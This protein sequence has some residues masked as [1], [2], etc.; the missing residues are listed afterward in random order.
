[1]Y[2]SNNVRSF[3]STYKEIKMT[4]CKLLQRL[5]LHRTHWKYLDKP[6]HRCSESK[7]NPNTTDCIANYIQRHI[8]CRAKTHG[9]RLYENR[10]ELAEC[11]SMEQFDKFVNISEA[12]EEADD[13][14][15]YEMTGCLSSCEKDKF[16]ITYGVESELRS[17]SFCRAL[18]SLQV[19]DKAFIEEE[20]YYIYDYDSF[21]ADVGGYM[22]LLLGT[23]VLSMYDVVGSWLNAA[24]LK[25]FFGIQ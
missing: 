10:T 12:L 18:V 16:D 21:W 20:Q 13:T 2:V 19:D 15:I 4:R 11:S 9:M 14:S 7:Q 8:G 25:S 17:A 1:M 3:G 5:H 24:R 6:S 23:S 22:G